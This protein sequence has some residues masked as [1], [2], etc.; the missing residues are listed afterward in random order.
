MIFLRATLLKSSK[1]HEKE[2]FLTAFVIL[3]QPTL[4][5]KII[6]EKNINKPS[7]LGFRYFAEV[8][9]ISIYVRQF[10]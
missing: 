10:V 3:N 5:F 6:F 8:V 7:F 9:P 4:D 1:I 2:Q